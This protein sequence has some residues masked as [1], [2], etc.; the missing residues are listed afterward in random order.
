MDC[1]RCQRESREDARF[2]D[3]CGAPLRGTPPAAGASPPAPAPTRPDYTPRHL[4]E[5]VLRS[6]SALEGE[7]KQVTVLF[8]DIQE[9]LALSEQ[10]DPEEW[11]RLLDRFFG[12]LARGVHR[13]EGTIN[14]YTG[15]GIMALFGAPIAHEDHAQRACYAA[16]DLG[17]RLRLLARELKRERGLSF[18]VRM[19]VNSGEVV[20]GRIGDDLRMDYTAQ[21]PTVG[22]AARLQS[23]A[24]PDT[25]YLSETTAA[26]AAGFFELEDLGAFQIRGAREEVGVYQLRGLGD[27]RTRLD[28][29][30]ARGLSRLVGRQEESKRLEEALERAIRGEGSVLAVVG[31]PGV[32]KS[33]LTFELAERCRRQGVAVRE[34]RGV[35][36][37]RMIPFLPVQE[38]MRGYFGIADEDP[39]ETARDKIA[40]RVVRLDPELADALPLLF[41][42]FGLPDAEAPEPSESAEVRERRLFEIIRRLVHARSEREPALIVIEDLQWLDGASERFVEN[43]ADSVEGTCTLLLLNQRPE[44]R[45]AWAEALPRIEL[46][47]LDPG[48]TDELLAE[49]LGRDPSLGELPRRIRQRAQGNPFFVEEL[50]QSLVDAGHLGGARGAYRLLERVDS[51]AIAPTVK[52]V[53][54]ARIDRLPERDKQLLQ[55]AA[56]IGQSFSQRLLEPVVE[57]DD[58]ELA[59]GLAALVEAEFVYEQAL[60]P[61]KE[62]AFKHPLTHEVAYSTQLAR[63]R[64]AVHRAVARGLHALDESSLD[65]R[66]ALLA[67]HWERAG[68]SQRAARWHRRAALRV[69]ANHFVEAA[70]HWSQVR[71]L[72]ERAPQNEET[73][74]MG[75]EARGQLIVAA[76]RLGWAPGEV[77]AV[78]AEAKRLAERSGDVRSLVRVLLHYGY[79]KSIS[80]ELD[81]AARRCAQARER[82]EETGDPDLRVAA[83]Y[84]QCSMRVVGVGQCRDSLPLLDESLAAT[85]A[86]PQAGTGVLGFPPRPVLRVMRSTVLAL[87]ERLDAHLRD[88]EAVAAE[89]GG[90]PATQLMACFFGVLVAERMGAADRAMPLA[91]RALEIAERMGFGSA[92][93]E[94]SLGRALLC[95]RAWG[96][97]AEVLRQGVARVR[98]QRAY[99]YLVPAF[100][101]ALARAELRSAPEAAVAAAEEALALAPSGGLYAAEAELV[102]TRSRLAVG[103]AREAA[104]VRA[105]LL[106]VEAVARRCGLAYLEP[107]VAEVRASLCRAEGDAAGAAR[108]HEEARRGYQRVG[109]NGQ[110]ARLAAAAS[111]GPG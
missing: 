100:L 31:E 88:I 53:L 37:G 76:A 27:A 78:F 110:A 103:G 73:L 9:S 50:V 54:A 81:E 86:S 82:V 75:V 8:A 7:R 56:V 98:G 59:A 85:E 16:L 105:S 23:L 57:L 96:D 102:E 60:Y 21:G 38:L 24:S 40:G 90:H 29:A 74:S 77:D 3:G 64:R 55:T 67:H 39:Q 79:S 92:Y 4:T 107:G 43:L 17:E 84:L 108:C 10:I 26:L 41:D 48:A 47:P 20:V 101:L 22:L 97:A 104:A 25:V 111:R 12:V 80:G 28:R 13:F 66:A 72:L 65:E 44:Y 99:L 5:R 68:D 49:I 6:R 1:P 91:R 34:A 71:A 95:S 30:R 18:S 87:S 33:R 70:G 15:D 62:Y 61:E 106:R 36:H 63:R 42:F 109:A 69:G 93:A 19:G 45:S 11:H 58:T 52:A 2:C 14:Q 32:G 51:L 94:L 89:D 46:A 35:S 83:L